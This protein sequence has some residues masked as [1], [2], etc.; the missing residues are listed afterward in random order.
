MAITRSMVVPAIGNNISMKPK[1]RVM[2]PVNTVKNIKSRK[3]E[4]TPPEL[5]LYLK[6]YKNWS[7]GG[8]IYMGQ[9]APS[10]K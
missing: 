6:Q 9:M 1:R 10:I 5:V 2:A 4:K 7:I 8:R 3:H